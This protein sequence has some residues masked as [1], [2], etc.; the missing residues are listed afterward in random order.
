MSGITRSQLALWL[1]GAG[2]AIFSVGL[3]SFFSLQNIG[4][5]LLGIGGLVDP[6]ALAS[7]R[8]KWLAIPLLYY[9]W[10]F[11]S[12][13][14][15]ANSAFF[16]QKMALYSLFL[17]WPVI[18]ML[19]RKRIL[20]DAR[21]YFKGFVLW[22]LLYAGAA[23]VLFLLHAPS[24]LSAMKRSASFPLPFHTHHIYYGAIMATAILLSLWLAL[25]ERAKAWLAVG[26]LLT[27]LFHVSVSRT[28]LAAFYVAFV[29]ALLLIARY[30]RRMKWAFGGLM[31]IT[32]F[33]GGAYL[34]SPPFRVKADTLFHEMQLLRQHANPNDRSLLIRWESWKA[35]WRIIQDY[36][37]RGTGIDRFPEAIRQ[38]YEGRTWLVP[39]QRLPPH[40]QWLYTAGALGLPGLLGLLLLTLWPLWQGIR[41]R[42]WLPVAW[43]ALM[44]VVLV[45]EPFLE[46]QTGIA[47]FMFFWTLWNLFLDEKSR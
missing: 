46:R 19:H 36:F 12:G 24:A 47:F 20:R 13:I 38:A 45:S 11:V 29:I 40:A 41:R 7:F 17:A 10:A 4:L 28:G 23:V 5:I 9:A 6:P 35:G 44:A 31:I 27:V 42:M 37:P 2:I 39:E 14:P 18:V 32:I 21:T 3:L 26:G 1:F 25:T 43:A 8:R 34:F 16:T 15:P 30:Y 33:I 22:V